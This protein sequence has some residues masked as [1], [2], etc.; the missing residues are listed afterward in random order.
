LICTFI[1]ALVTWMCLITL[2]SGYKSIFN[3][4]SLEF[5]LHLKTLSTTKSSSSSGN[6]SCQSQLHFCI[7]MSS[8]EVF[9]AMCVYMCFL[10]RGTQNG[11][12]YIYFF[13]HKVDFSFSLAF[14]K[15][16]SFCMCFLMYK[17]LRSKYLRKMK[18]DPNAGIYS[19]SSS[20]STL[21]LSLIITGKPDC[22]IL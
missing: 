4:N 11:P 19:G 10:A 6:V 13:N 12:W 20:L 8:D 7:R 17:I 21:D 5:I 9:G 15:S 18:Y 16:A 22:G 1:C 2:I 3:L 14:C